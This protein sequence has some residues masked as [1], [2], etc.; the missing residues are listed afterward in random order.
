MPAWKFFLPI[1]RKTAAKTIIGWQSGMNTSHKCFD[2]RFDY[3][4]IYIKAA[5]VHFVS[6]LHGSLLP[7]RSFPTQNSTPTSTSINWLLCSSINLYLPLCSSINRHQL[8]TLLQRNRHL[9][10]CSS[11]ER[12]FRASMHESLSLSNSLTSFL[13]CMVLQKRIL[14]QEKSPAHTPPPP[15]RE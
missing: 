4:H 3:R 6:L 12:P 2:R 13:C 10:L 8:T 14:C 1:V 9:P 5:P 11:V 7:L 15:P